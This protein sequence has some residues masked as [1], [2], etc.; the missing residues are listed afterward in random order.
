M[1]NWLQSRNWK[2]WLGDGLLAVFLLGSASLFTGAF[3]IFAEVQSA[4]QIVGV[5]GVAVWFG[6]PFLGQ[7]IPAGLSDYISIATPENPP[8]SDLLFSLS[9][10]AVVVAAW[11]FVAW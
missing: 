11:A 5:F 10:P 9:S 6:V 3:G 2:C 7:V 4:V 8:L 1:M